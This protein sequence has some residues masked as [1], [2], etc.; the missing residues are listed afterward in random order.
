MHEGAAA[1][2]VDDRFGR[3]GGQLGHDVVAGFAADEEA[4]EGAGGTD[5]GGGSGPRLSGGSRG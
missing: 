2:L 4:A 3:E 1:G 5:A